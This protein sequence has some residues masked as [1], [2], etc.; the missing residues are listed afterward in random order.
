[1]VQPVPA[2]LVVLTAPVSFA[3][4]NAGDTRISN[5]K[6]VKTRCMGIL[7]GFWKT[8]VSRFAREPVFSGSQASRLTGVVRRRKVGRRFDAILSRRRADCKT[9]PIPKPLGRVKNIESR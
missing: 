5:D 4:V 1:M 6:Q 3:R 9:I 8:L 7:D 2:S